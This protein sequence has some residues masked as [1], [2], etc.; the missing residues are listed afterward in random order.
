MEWAIPIGSFDVAKLRVTSALT[1][2]LKPLA[3]LSYE[4]GP[5]HF[6]HVT[7]LLPTLPVKTYDSSTGRLILSLADAP[8]VLAKLTAIQDAMQSAVVAHQDAWFRGSG[9]SRQE[10]LTGFQPLLDGTNL[11]LYCPGGQGA[12]MQHDLQIYKHGE[13]W[14]TGPTSLRT[15]TSARVALRLQGIS[16]H[17]SSPRAWSGKYRLQHRLLTAILP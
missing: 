1:T 5:F 14:R 9:R 2:G 12:S 7:I 13:G 16:F 11:L 10:I 15:A 6:S 8:A 17:L 4:D 3:S